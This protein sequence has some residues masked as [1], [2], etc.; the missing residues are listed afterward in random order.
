VLGSGTNLLLHARLDP[1]EHVLTIRNVRHGNQRDV[2]LIC[3]GLDATANTAANRWPTV[4][5]KTYNVFGEGVRSQTTPADRTGRLVLQRRRLQATSPNVVDVSFSIPEPD[6]P[7][8]GLLLWTERD[9]GK[10]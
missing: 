7:L 5:P 9:P 3:D 6:Y 4:A 8:D 1:G 10:E 2:Q